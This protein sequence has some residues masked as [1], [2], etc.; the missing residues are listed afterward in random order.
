[1]RERAMTLTSAREMYTGPVLQWAHHERLDV[2]FV[3]AGGRGHWVAIANRQ[4]LG[5]DYRRLY[6]CRRVVA[7]F[8][9]CHGGARV[10]QQS[11]GDG[12]GQ[13][14]QFDACDAGHDVSCET[15]ASAHY[16]L[17]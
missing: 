13:S 11:C 8:V 2:I 1:M 5:S 15:H 10:R 6:F 17:L 14:I 12:K 4:H 7:G 3:A 16:R 9:T